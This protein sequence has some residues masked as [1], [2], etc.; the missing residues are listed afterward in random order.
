MIFRRE[1]IIRPANTKDRQRLANLIHFEVH[2]H[3]HL[4]WRGPLDWISSS[5][6]L[7]V[8]QGRELLASLACPPDPPY[9]GWV[10]MFAVAQGYSVERAWKA[11]WP[12]ALEELVNLEQVTATAAIPLWPW[13]EELLR[14][15][16]FSEN[17]R[18]VMMSWERGDAASLINHPGI[19]I[20]PMNLEDVKAVEWIDSAAFRPLWQNS[21]S[22]LELAFRQAVL[23]TVAEDQSKI[24]GYQISTA[25]PVGGHLARLAVVPA[26]QGMGIGTALVEDLIRQFKRQGA[27][28]V[29]VNTQKDNLASLS[30]YGKAGFNLTGEEYPV[31]QFEI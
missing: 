2:V 4:D 22:S 28:R 25:T 27:Q 17:N 13:F 26:Y 30:L 31:Y 18:V 3:R 19:A 7:V 8:E 23:A 20:R 12:K 9:I 6:Y 29:T 24:L 16:G 15:S 14:K 5:P 11:L 10:R 21:F 1:P